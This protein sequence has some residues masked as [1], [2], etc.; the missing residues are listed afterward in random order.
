M[1]F[2]QSCWH[3]R[4]ATGGRVSPDGVQRRR[5]QRLVLPVAPR[6]GLEPGGPANCAPSRQETAAGHRLAI[7]RTVLRRR[8]SSP[9]ASRSAG[10]SSVG[11]LGGEH[12]RLVRS[13]WRFEQA[14]AGLPA[15][16]IGQFKPTAAS[17]AHQYPDDAT[18]ATFTSRNRG[19]LDGAAGVCA[20]AR[21][22]VAAVRWFFPDIRPPAT[23]KS[24]GGGC[25]APAGPAGTVSGA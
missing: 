6:P 18:K 4:T 22:V 9:I 11:D 16:A 7:T 15:S 5:P 17:D 25:A 1:C 23:R 12:R 10:C 20:T 3:A 19:Y 2:G 13:G 24:A 14:E 8:R 21:P